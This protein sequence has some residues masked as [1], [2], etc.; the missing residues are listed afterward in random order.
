MAA[1]PIWGNTALQSALEAYRV[2][3]TF[4]GLIWRLFVN[5]H[6]PAAGDVGSDYTEASWSSYVA[7]TGVTW[8]AATLAANIA[9]T[10]SDTMD[11]PVGSG[12]GGVTVYG[13]YA[14]DGG[15]V[16]YHA[17][18]FDTPIVTVGGLDVQAIV[19]VRLRN[20]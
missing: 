11:W 12:D 18:K 5:N 6:T 10:E 1:I 20:P 19:R 8:A 9:Y 15:G 2:A 4:T 13:I 16:L 3:G 14:T 17:V 7:V